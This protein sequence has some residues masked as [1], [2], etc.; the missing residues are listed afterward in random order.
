M[1]VLPCGSRR[2]SSGVVSRAS[3]ILTMIERRGSAS[4]DSILSKKGRPIPIMSE[5]VF[6][7]MWACWRIRLTFCPK[8]D[9]HLLSL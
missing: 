3:A 1:V 2:S 6:L 9:E 5:N 8:T 7:F 4:P